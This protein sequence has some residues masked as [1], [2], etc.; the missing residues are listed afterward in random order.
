MRRL[1][2]LA[3]VVLFSLAVVSVTVLAPHQTVKLSKAAI[4]RLDE[5]NQILDGILED[6]AAGVP[7]LDELTEKIEEAF[8]AFNKVLGE[9]PVAGLLFSEVF[10]ATL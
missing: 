7:G 4:Q 10:T 8:T 6:L 5:L 3:L 2:G 9:M 1:F